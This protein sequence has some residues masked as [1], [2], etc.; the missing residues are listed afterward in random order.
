MEMNV[1]KNLKDL[2]GSNVKIFNQFLYNGT[3]QNLYIANET[4]GMTS[5]FKPNKKA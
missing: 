4:T 2:Y 1:S 5:L 3:Y